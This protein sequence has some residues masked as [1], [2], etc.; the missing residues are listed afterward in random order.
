[1]NSGS[2]HRSSDAANIELAFAIDGQNRL[3]DTTSEE[4][5]VAAVCHREAPDATEGEGDAAS[6]QSRDRCEGLLHTLANV[7]TGILMNAQILSWK[8]PPYSCLKRPLREIENHALRAA[9]LVNLLSC[10][11]SGAIRTSRLIQNELREYLPPREG[12][13]VTA[14][15]PAATADLPPA[16]NRLKAPGFF[17][18][19]RQAL[20]TRCDVSPSGDFPKRDDR[21][22]H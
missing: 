1:M 9:E 5:D 7:V 12:I 15:E 21:D 20:T 8:V 6:A 22:E 3:A 2:H 19:R 13:A 4:R 14:Q 11:L 17:R 16:A 10:E 18:A